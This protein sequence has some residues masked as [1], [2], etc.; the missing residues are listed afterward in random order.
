M[1]FSQFVNI[2]F[3]EWNLIHEKKTTFCSF[4]WGKSWREKGIQNE[5]LDPW[6]YIL[7]EIIY[8]NITLSVFFGHILQSNFKCAFKH[9]VICLHFLSERIQVQV[10]FLSKRFTEHNDVYLRILFRTGNVYFGFKRLGFCTILAKE[11]LFSLE[12]TTFHLEWVTS[13]CAISSF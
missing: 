10:A 13:F 12:Q 4:L 11:V 9:Q 6:T 8:L 2:I 3:Q 5:M 7:F 1:I